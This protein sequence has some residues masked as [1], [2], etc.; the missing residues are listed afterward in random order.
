MAAQVV[1][2]DAEFLGEIAVDLTHPRQVALP[3]AMDQED[4]RAVRIAPLLRRDGEAVRCLHADRLVFRRLRGDLRDRGKQ[5]R[6]GQRRERA[7]AHVHRHGI[8]PRMV[9]QCFERSA[10]PAGAERE[11]RRPT[12]TCA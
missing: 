10:H 8:P 2:D 11:A 6:A 7:D 3:E 4:F 5:S 12:V 9:F 1:G